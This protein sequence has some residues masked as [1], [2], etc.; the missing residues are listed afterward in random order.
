MIAYQRKRVP[1]LTYELLFKSN[2]AIDVI[3]K[4]LVKFIPKHEIIRL[5]SVAKSVRMD[6]DIK[7]VSEILADEVHKSLEC[8]DL[9]ILCGTLQ[10]L[11]KIDSTKVKAS[12]IFVDEAGQAT[13][14]D[15]LVVWPILA[16]KTGQLI[17]AGTVI[18]LLK[19]FHERNPI[20]SL[21]GIS[22]LRSKHFFILCIIEADL[23]RIH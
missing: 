16:Q 9:K 20:N 22:S 13:E 3:V 21:F 5:V 18:Q 6:K 14:S 15:I 23:K 17:L 4:K 2:T 19:S 11:G 1:H 7:Q 12:H 10:I 8:G